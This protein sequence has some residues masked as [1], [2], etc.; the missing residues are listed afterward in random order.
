[1]HTDGALQMFGIDFYSL[2]GILH[3]LRIKNAISSKKRLL[4][5][6]LCTVCWEANE[7]LA[8]TAALGGK[9]APSRRAQQSGYWKRG[10]FR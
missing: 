10:Y 9:V 1:M 3:F 4:Y 2:I 7:C 6:S 8:T 5:H